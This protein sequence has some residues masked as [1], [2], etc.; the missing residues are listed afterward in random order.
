MYQHEDVGILLVLQGAARGLWHLHPD[1]QEVSRPKA[2]EAVEE[3]DKVA[4]AH[5]RQEKVVPQTVPRY[6]SGLLAKHSDQAGK[7]QAPRLKASYKGCGQDM[8]SSKMIKGEEMGITWL[9]SSV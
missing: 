7:H 5:L 4:V 8:I 3:N 9:T 2:T 6:Q 1:R